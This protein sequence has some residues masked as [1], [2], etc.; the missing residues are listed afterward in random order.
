M[1]CGRCD[2]L[3]RGLRLHGGLAPLLKAIWD[4]GLALQTG[5]LGWWAIFRRRAP[6]FPPMPTTGLF[7]F[8]RQPIYVAFTLT[9]WS[10]PTWTPDQLAVAVVLTGYCLIGP[11]MK[12]ARF[13]QR[14]GAA[15]VA[16]T[17]RSPTGF[18]G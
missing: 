17:R 7:R 1:A 6:V 13:R 10:V 11:L 9:L 15:F 4:A 8:V 14:F 12:E 18:P 16:Y 2:A 5:H 3:A